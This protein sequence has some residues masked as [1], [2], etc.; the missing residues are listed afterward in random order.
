MYVVK[1]ISRTYVESYTTCGFS[2]PLTVDAAPA[3]QFGDKWCTAFMEVLKLE[4]QRRFGVFS[5]QKARFL[6]NF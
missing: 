2:F 1:K 4:W 6:I 3:V 5:K